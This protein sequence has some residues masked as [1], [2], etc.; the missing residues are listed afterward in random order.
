MR[1]QEANTGEELFAVLLS[2]F[3]AKDYLET[4]MD[5]TTLRFTA[6]IW[7]RANR[8]SMVANIT[9]PPRCRRTIIPASCARVL[10]TPCAWGRIRVTVDLAITDKDKAM[11]VPTRQGLANQGV[12][13]VGG[14]LRLRKLTRFVTL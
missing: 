11:A 6:P 9:L 2:P 12:T 10:A 13:R 8:A 3:L 4:W 7:A 14:V 1:R 5:R